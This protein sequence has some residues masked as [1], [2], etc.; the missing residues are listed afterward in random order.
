M[1]PLKRTK[2][3]DK[4]SEVLVTRRAFLIVL[5]IAMLGTSAL[6]TL[7][8]MQLAIGPEGPQGEQGI[9]GIQGEQGPQGLQ[10]EK[11]DTGLQGPQGETGPQGA[12]GKQGPQ[13]IQGIQG[14]KGDKGEQG[15]IGP[16]GPPGANVLIRFYEPNETVKVVPANSGWTAWKNASRVFT[17]S[18]MNSSNNAVL[19]IH[20]WFEYKT[21]TTTFPGGV[22]DLFVGLNIICDDVQ[23]LSETRKTWEQL[24][25]DYTNSGV[26]VH[27]VPST[28]CA[29]YQFWFQVRSWDPGAGGPDW[30]AY[31][32]NLNIVLTVADG[33]PASNP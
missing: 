27:M 16:Q 29:R 11:G 30:K 15:E 18:P 5:I 33:L 2:V 14:P 13:G 32:R 19:S 26:T 24:D 1:Q 9:Q 21:N 7:A 10:G 12:Q 23:T 17:W 4:M 8:S 22:H 31:I 6:S 28:N 25:L 20:M 3:G